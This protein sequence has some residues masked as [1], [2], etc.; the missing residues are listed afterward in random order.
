[1]IQS[2]DSV[3]IGVSGGKD[4]LLLLRALA[5]YRD[6]SPRP[7]ALSA[8]TISP[9]LEP[10]DLS[11]VQQMCD[12]LAVPY[13]I[14]RTEIGKIIFEERKEPNPCALCSKMRR[15]ALANACNELGVNKLA[16]GHHRDDA[17]E[18]L[19]MSLLFEGRFHTF[20]PVTHLERSNITQIRPLIYS[21]E[22][23]ILALTRRLALP[24]VESPCPA[25]RHT[26]REE[27]KRLM[28]ELCKKYPNARSQILSALKN[29]A[30]YGLWTHDDEM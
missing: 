11:G 8:I 20:Q 25:N 9:G 13:H 24:V 23:Q 21:S 17:I 22:K 16:L 2:G 10:F 4:S 28:D 12:S 3:A 18:T 14:V 1:M 30:Q 19:L 29:E 27:M 26:R 6:F 7:F 15:G 5:L